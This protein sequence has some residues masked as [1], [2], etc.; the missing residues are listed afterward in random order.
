MG[1]S[2]LMVCDGCR[3]HIR[4]VRTVS[5]AYMPVEPTP[6]DTWLDVRPQSATALAAWRIRHG[7]AADGRH[8]AATTLVDEA[9]GVTYTGVVCAPPAFGEPAPDGHR[10][11]RGYE[12]H[13]IRCDQAARF[14]RKRA[15]AGP[16][17]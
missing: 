5:G 13:F 7:F 17:P 3:A 2:A 8:S 1:V 16:P 9:S 6:Q 11:V 12:P 15:P 4:F 10:H 14:R